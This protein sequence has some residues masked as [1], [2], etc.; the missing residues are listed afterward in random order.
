MPLDPRKTPIDGTEYEFYLLPVK[1]QLRLST[2]FFKLGL[3]PI[4][5]LLAAVASQK[6]KL[7]DIFKTDFDFGAVLGLIADRLDEEEVLQIVES[8]LTSVRIASKPVTLDGNFQ[9]KLTVLFKVLGEALQENFADFFAELK[10][11]IPV[12][13]TT[14]MTPDPQ[15]STGPSGGSSSRKSPQKPK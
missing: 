9:G 6:G 2:R 7:A 1:E 5:K 15:T 11:L 8:L 10:D 3:A 14:A 13:R 4:G 12:V